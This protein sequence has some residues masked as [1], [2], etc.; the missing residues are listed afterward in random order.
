MAIA[1]RYI[2][3]IQRDYAE[4]AFA[5]QARGIYLSRK[6]KLT[7]RIKNMSS[8]LIPLIF[9]SL[10]RIETISCAMELRSF[11]TQKKR[12]WYSSRPFAQ[13]DYL[14]NIAVILILIV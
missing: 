12:T 5:P 4:I 2:P 11:G 8:I 3:D 10:E 9:N 7:K 13:R 6:E 1:L 14:A